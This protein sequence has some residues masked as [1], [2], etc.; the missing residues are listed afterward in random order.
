M[1]R[2]TYEEKKERAGIIGLVTDLDRDGPKIYDLYKGCQDVEV[3]FDAM[4]NHLDADKTYLQDND[5]VRGY[6]FV[7]FLALRIYFRILKR[8]HAN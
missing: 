1:D 5:A 7:T 8:L 2:E 3:A 4:K 6:Y